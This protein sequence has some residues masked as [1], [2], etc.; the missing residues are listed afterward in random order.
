MK[1]VYFNILTHFFTSVP[2]SSKTYTSHH[3]SEKQ[4]EDGAAEMV[5]ETVEATM[6]EADPPTVVPTATTTT[7]GTTPTPAT[8]QRAPTPERP[9][10]TI[11]LV[12][13]NS[14]NNTRPTLHRAGMGLGPF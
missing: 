5:L 11:V 8:T 9:A 1:A 3:V 7:I 12:L 2:E 10:P 4:S 14:N 6:A 13:D